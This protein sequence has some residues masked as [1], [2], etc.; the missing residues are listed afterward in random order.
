MADK[1]ISAL[2]SATTPLAGTEVL[3]I[4][5]SSTTVKVA[6]SDLTVGQDVALKTVTA[7]AA[8]IQD[9][10]K[11][12][13]RAGGTGSYIATITPTTLSAS[14]TVTLPDAN[15]SIPVA[16]QIL[17]YS[18]PTAARTI[19]LPDANFTAA[20]TDAAQSF[21]GDQTLS[22][23][24]LV[25]SNGKGID[26]SATPGTGTSELFADYEEGT[27]TPSI[28]S[29]TAGTG[30]ATTVNSAKYTKTG[31][32][33]FVEADI[34]LTTLGSGGSG[35]FV[36]LGLPFT[37]S[38]TSSGT[39]ACTY[40]VGLLGN[41]VGPPN[42][43]ASPNTTYVILYTTGTV[44]ANPGQEASFATYAKAGLSLTFSCTYTV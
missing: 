2:T 44:N 38:T 18:G 24:N 1:T 39:G 8:A 19:T 33:V 34:S 15:T 9:G 13:G 4:V 10:V 42:V 11:L 35:S 12:A 5:Q 37:S 31:R 41:S 43:G 3:P 28:D 40:V 7:T 36:I 22:T 32:V 17:T 25:V 30:R 29:K 27:W 6:V 20:R 16:T 21:T 26:F 23:G 14:R